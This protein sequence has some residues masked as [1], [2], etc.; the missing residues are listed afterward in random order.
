MEGTDIRKAAIEVVRVL[1]ENKIPIALAQS[2]FKE[3][4][5]LIERNTIPYSPDK[6]KEHSR[7]CALSIKVSEN[8]SKQNQDEMESRLRS[9][10]SISNGNTAFDTI[11]DLGIMSTEEACEY[12]EIVKFGLK[13]PDEDEE[14]DEPC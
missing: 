12:T 7:D 4:M 14:S 3:A 8:N 13:L 9:V 6:K 10:L 1:H 2:V 11:T 5:E